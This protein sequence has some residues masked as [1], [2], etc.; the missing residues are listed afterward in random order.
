MIIRDYFDFIFEAAIKN[1]IIIYY[2]SKFRKILTIMSTKNSYAK[3]LLELEGTPDFNDIHSFIDITDKNDTISFLEI[4]R[5]L[6]LDPTISMDSSG[7]YFSDEQKELFWDKGRS[8]IGIGRWFRKIMSDV[9][10]EDIKDSDIEKFVND[11]K[12]AFDGKDDLFEIVTGEDIRKY[13]LYTNYEFSIGQL[14]NSC[15][16][17]ERCQDYLDI[18][19]KNPEVCSLLIRKSIN[20]PSK[21][22]G[23]SLLW[24]LENGRKYQDRI[25]TI[26][27][28]D[29][30]LFESWATNN[31]YHIYDDL[32]NEIRVKLGDFEYDNFPYMDTFICYNPSTKVLSSNEDLWP[33]N[34]YNFLQDT[35]GGYTD[36]DVVY[37]EWDDT[38]HPRDQVVYC[39]NANSY[40]YRGSAYFLEYRN[41]WAVENGDIARAS[42]G[43]W[44]YKDDLVFSE[45][46][47]KYSLGIPWLLPDDPH[48]IEIIIDNDG[49]IDYCDKRYPDV[50]IE[51]DG[52]YYK[53][54]IVAIDP[55]TDELVFLDNKDLIKK[56]NDEL[57]DDLENVKEMLKEKLKGELPKNIKTQIKEN[58]LYE[59]IQYRA[60]E[61]EIYAIIKSIM[62]CGYNANDGL[63]S[64]INPD[65]CRYYAYFNPGNSV[66]DVGMVIYTIFRLC[67]MLDYS[68]FPKD[69]YK[70]YLYIVLKSK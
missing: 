43:K 40:V 58:G 35:E 52:L 45:I 55:Y 6:R 17:Y 60:S 69:I 3:K 28:S 53:K 14:G 37:C 16:R 1:K 4:N 38:Y 44:Y 66:H 8:E 31:S 10:K 5:A 36:S 11:Y 13:Y 65:F 70:L 25:Y 29:K 20:N 68:K 54:T 19:V 61:G 21:I 26:R 49:D 2:S 56:I 23:R 50:Y 15:M 46:M 18:Y 32:S 67:K 47:N 63:W 27:D 42:N 30:V 33:G 62:L 41:E 57:G 34:G 12:A 39:D 51:K 7:I 64:R 22:V 24:K 48:T 9:L 59:S